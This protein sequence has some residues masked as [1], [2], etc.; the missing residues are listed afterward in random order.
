MCRKDLEGWTIPFLTAVPNHFGKGVEDCLLKLCIRYLQSKGA[1]SVSLQVHPELEW[2]F[3][4][5][6][7]PALA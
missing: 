4:T 7:Q 5:Q 2:Q 3:E 1:H 6:V